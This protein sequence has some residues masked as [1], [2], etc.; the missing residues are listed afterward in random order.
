MTND[1]AFAAIADPTRRRLLDR[2]AARPCS[3]A[4][5]TRG[6]RVSQPAISQHLK[7]L[8]EAGLVT[9]TPRGA[10]TI[11][12]VDPAGLGPIRAWLDQFWA[13]QLAA[14][15]AAAA[16]ESDTTDEP[17]RPKAD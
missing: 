1:N 10:S 5:L 9:A 7:V 12:S 13:A 15:A 2:L 17:K 8:R 6:E 14:F 3:V 16:E 4:E 11:Y